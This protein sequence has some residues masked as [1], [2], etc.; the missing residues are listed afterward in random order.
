MKNINQLKV[1]L[2]L[3]VGL[4]GVGY[5]SES[6]NDSSSDRSNVEVAPE[7]LV[8]AE[9]TEVKQI[10]LFGN[11][12]SDRIICMNSKGNFVAG[13]IPFGAVFRCFVLPTFIFDKLADANEGN[14]SITEYGDRHVQD[15]IIQQMEK[16]KSLL[17]D[18]QQSGSNLV[19]IKENKGSE[20][21]NRYF[22]VDVVGGVNYPCEPEQFSTIYSIRIS[23]RLFQMMMRAVFGERSNEDESVAR[24]IYIVNNTSN[25]HFSLWE[26]IKN[27]PLCERVRNFSLREG[28]EFG[29]WFGM[30]FCSAVNLATSIPGVSSSGAVLSVGTGIAIGYCVA[31]SGLLFL[32]GWKMV[33]LVTAPPSI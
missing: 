32:S 28:I 4:S 26:R 9:D 25:R 7:N 23:P 30:Y 13:A 6:H 31:A 15:S 33:Q 14:T 20:T 24:S 18:S 17:S 21:E 1:M 11:A 3:V 19:L 8:A 12:D 22:F 10:Y 29:L 5:G 27:C 2:T 16:Q